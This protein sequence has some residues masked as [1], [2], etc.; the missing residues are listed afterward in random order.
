[1]NAKGPQDMIVYVLNRNGRVESTNYRTVQNLTNQNVPE[2]IKAEFADFYRAMFD[3]V[4][5]IEK[6][7]SVVTE[8]LLGHGLVRSV[9]QRSRAAA[10]VARTRLQLA[11]RA[12]ITNARR[13]QHLHHPPACA[14]RPRALPGGH[15]VSGNR[16]QAVHPG[17]LHHHHPWRGKAKTEEGRAYFAG[18]PK[19]F[20]EEAKTA[21][22]LTG[23][24]IER[25]R[26]KQSAYKDTSKNPDE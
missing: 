7:S 17:T 2:F 15:R 12:T 23:W 20:E 26:A 19:R 3:R 14:L 6:M 25:I 18:L 5:E 22:R 4:M 24:P 10:R 21:A 8:Y 1:V 11:A 9:Q 13:R 16:G